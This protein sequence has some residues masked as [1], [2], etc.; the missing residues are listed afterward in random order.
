MKILMLTPYL[1]FPLMSGGQTRSYNLIMNLSKKHEI[2][3]FSLIKDN[4]ERKYIPELLKFC[5]NV[6]VFNR[7]PK[8]WTLHN[9]LRTGFGTYPFLVVRNL[10]TK[11]SGAIEEE[12]SSNKYD[13]IHAETFYVMPHIPI[14]NTPPILLVEQT[15]EYLVYKHYVTET[16]SKL[17]APLL[18]IDVMKLKF[19][20]RYY[21]KRAKKVVA[22][23]DSD[24]VQMEI[25]SP[26]LS[27][28]IV[29]NG[30]DTD[31]FAGKKREKPDPPKVLY[32]GNF[33]WLQNIE[34]V[35]LLINKVW[36]KIKK[37]VPQAKL[38]IVGM[39]MTDYIR[40]LKSSD[41]DVSEGM[42]DIRDAYRKSTVLVTPIRGP[43]G[44]RL[45]I[46]E[47]MA[48]SLPVV[49]TTVGAEGL[50]VKNGKEALVE[51]N[52]EDLVAST[53]KIL[54]DPMLAQKL[55]TSGW[56][57]VRKNY[58]WDISAQKLSRIY[59]EIVSEK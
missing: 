18:S 55:G 8:P 17:L 40:N 1:P 24:R 29:P 13:L 31:Y 23:S 47:A 5:K 36:P 35:E 42:P 34:A 7:P 38:W 27:I 4:A 21:W 3:L 16:A 19:W 25:L 15:V 54:K 10:A 22:M 52:L 51:D 9:I 43:G 46:L 48:S 33:T 6:R 49:T 58:T 39:H 41:I 57:F 32:V 44:T 37:Q 20:E 50:G 56:D 2:T 59:E 12:L 28:D 53:V 14:T 11:Q 45:K 30:I 26:G